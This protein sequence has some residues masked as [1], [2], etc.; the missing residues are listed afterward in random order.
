M[1]I[2][3]LNPGGSLGG[4]ERCLL[5]LVASIRA[6]SRREDMVLGL[7]AGGNGPLLAEAEALGVRVVRLPLSERMAAVGDSAI[8]SNGGARAFATSRL[9]N[10]LYR[11]LYDV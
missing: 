9:G 6:S 4:A 5:D 8:V 3:F 10:P 2:L 1:R 7:V 11:P